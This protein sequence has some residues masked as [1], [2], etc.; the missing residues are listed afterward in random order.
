MLVT[1]SAGFVFHWPENSPY[2]EVFRK[3]DEDWKPFEIIWAGDLEYGPPALN[4]IAHSSR[5]YA[6]A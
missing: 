6:H 3:G 1:N 4:V 5:E 2:I